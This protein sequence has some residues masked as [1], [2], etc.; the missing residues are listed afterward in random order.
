MVDI[1]FIHFQNRALE[2]ELDSCLKQSVGFA[3]QAKTI[4]MLILST[5]SEISWDWMISKIYL[6]ISW[7]NNI[8]SFHFLK[9]LPSNNLD[10]Y[11][12]TIFFFYRDPSE[13]QRA[14]PQVGCLAYS[15]YQK[16]CCFIRTNPNSITHP[17]KGE[18]THPEKTKRICV[19]VCFF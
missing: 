12:D 2:I 11:G 6:F 5:V 18:G 19:C 4:E 17:I 15:K 3:E 10:S 7:F 13:W 1:Y 16:S 8:V 14:A 9:H